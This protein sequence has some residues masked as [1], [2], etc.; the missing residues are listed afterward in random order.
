MTE[1]PLDVLGVGNAIVD[2]LAKA[3][4]AELE[5]PGLA[6]GAMTLTDP[7]RA[8]QLYGQMGD[9]QARKRRG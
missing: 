4:D 7:E 1:A 3:D 5:R 8:Q 2:V 6:T 9:H